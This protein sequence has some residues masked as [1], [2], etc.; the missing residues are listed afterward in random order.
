[1]I[2]VYGRYLADQK[3]Q[4]P[5]SKGKCSTQ[6]FFLFSFF[7]QI[8]SVIWRQAVQGAVCCSRRAYRIGAIIHSIFEIDRC[9]KV[10]LKG[11][12]PF[13]PESAHQL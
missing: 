8:L 5:A 1:M 2:F 3:A 4:Q 7:L 12:P 9:C 6:M 10:Y 11:V 13:G